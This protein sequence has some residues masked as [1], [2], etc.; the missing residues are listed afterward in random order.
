M[1]SNFFFY[2][3]GVFSVVVIAIPYFAD[4]LQPISLRSG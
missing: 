2:L 1:F 3:I 4:L